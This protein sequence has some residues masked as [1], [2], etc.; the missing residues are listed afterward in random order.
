MGDAWDTVHAK[1][2]AAAA[3]GLNRDRLGVR[4][5]YGGRLGMGGSKLYGARLGGDR[6]QTAHARRVAS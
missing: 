1:A 3:G 2:A 6:V 4:K 5:P